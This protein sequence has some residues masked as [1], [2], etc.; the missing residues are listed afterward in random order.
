MLTLVAYLDP[1]SESREQRERRLAEEKAVKANG[2]EKT[3]GIAI[4]EAKGSDLGA[5]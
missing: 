2:A 1:N 4:H 3:N 5:S